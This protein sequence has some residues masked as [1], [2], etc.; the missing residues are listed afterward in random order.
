MSWIAVGIIGGAVVGGV[1]SNMSA[2][3][4]AKA[5]KN[6]GKVDITHETTPWGPSVQNRTDLMNRATQLGLQDQPTFDSWLGGKGSAGTPAATGGGKRAKGK[7]AG[8]GAGT[9]APKAPG[10]TGVSP[11]TNQVRQ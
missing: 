8:K 1:A 2:S 10:F 11:E 9:V 5:M 6:A 4:Q 7:K 3:K